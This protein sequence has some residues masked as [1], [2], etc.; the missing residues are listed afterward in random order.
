MEVRIRNTCDQLP[1]KKEVEVSTD[2]K[3]VNACDVFD[4]ALLTGDFPL[5]VEGVVE[6][7]TDDALL[8]GVK[9]GCLFGASLLC[10]QREDG[11]SSPS[12]SGSGATSADLDKRHI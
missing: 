5:L 9:L 12:S 3:S 11:D 4:V 2:P 7:C 10:V 8:S 1:S 6:N